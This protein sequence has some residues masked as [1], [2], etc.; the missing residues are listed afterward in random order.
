LEKDRLLLL[1]AEMKLPGKAWLKFTVVPEGDG[2]RLSVD[3]YYASH[4]LAGKIYWY[5][6]LPFHYFIFNDLIRQ[7]ERRSAA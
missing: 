6:F 7:I 3:A 5:N 1:R 4:G 2:S